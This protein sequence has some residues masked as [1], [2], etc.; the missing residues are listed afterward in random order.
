[1]NSKRMWIM[2]TLACVL[3]CMLALRMFDLQVVKTAVLKQTA[4][5]NRF[6]HK[7]VVADRGILFD[8]FGQS[9]VFNKPVFYQLQSPNRLYSNRTLVDEST[10][11]EL[12]AT[13]SSSVFT[14][15]Y[16]EYIYPDALSQVTGYVGPI[17]KEDLDRDPNLALNQVIGKVGLEAMFQD[18][19]KGQ[20]GAVVY[21]TNAKGEIIRT[22]SEQNSVSGQHI[23]TTIDGELTA[24]I[25][26]LM[27]GQKGAVLVGDPGTGEVLSL[28]SSPT[29][30]ANQFTRPP[31]NES[32]DENKKTQL[33]SYFQDPNK[34]FFNRA[35]AGGYPPG[36]V[37]KPVTALGALE[38]GAVDADTKVDDQGTLK[39]GEFE[40]GNWFYRQY[41]RIEGSINLV[42]A[43]ARSNDIYFY[44]A[45]EWLGANQLAAIARMVG[46]GKRT[47]I[48]LPAEASG[49]V[50]DPAW[51]EK[52]VGE[53]WYLGDTYHF[54]IG[55]GDLLVTPVQVFQSLTLFANG[56]KLCA[57]T[58]IK[59]TSGHCQDISVSQDH[60]KTIEEGLK[61]VCTRGGTAFPFFPWNDQEENKVFCKT[62]TAEFGA[63][64]N[65]GHRRTHGWFVGFTHLNTQ[66]RTIRLV[67]NGR[68]EK[69]EV[70]E[71]YPQNILVVVLVESDEVKPFREGSAD[72]G[73]IALKILEWIKDH[74]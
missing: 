40:Y 68:L 50:P 65:N 38:N 3:V 43:L 4:E 1:M 37:F 61:E 41:G 62:G 45:A 57:P 25:F 23:Q 16:R 72:G 70:K 44:K 2:P 58:L 36:S 15:Q 28:I 14:D 12:M 42:R 48:E 35:L 49:I 6:F 52:A 24:Y 63:A 13:A 47:G 10:A 73:P 11:L 71:Q 7:V 67:K 74:R 9:L 27:K 34:L 21:E 69:T 46:F 8:R 51:K 39:V 29:F 20:D 66:P 26:G 54:G 30:N 19:L 18:E 60:L 59:G 5:N 17:T 55:Q 32:D 64:D 56:G 22:V 53:K 33:A 31:M